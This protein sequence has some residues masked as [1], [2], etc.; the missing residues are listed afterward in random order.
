MG[1][2]WK[3]FW[4]GV[5]VG[6]PLLLFGGGEV[7][8]PAPTLRDPVFKAYYQSYNYEKMGD[9]RDAIRVLLPLYSKYPKSYTLN[10]RLGWLTYLNRQYG[11]SIKFYLKAIQALPNSIEP[12]L[13]LM[14][15]YLAMGNYD[16]SLAQGLVILK[17]DLYNYYG[18]LYYILG[19]EKKGLYSNEIILCEKML[20]LY[21][22]SVPFLVRLGVAKYLN[23]DKKEAKQIFKNVLILDPNN[24]TAK[25]YL[26]E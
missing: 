14:K 18:N 15:V 20:A 23:G 21:P 16:D 22:T 5:G 7:P 25:E 11:N 4:I 12:R 17:K 8:T 19:L 13:G 6:V 1:L 24:V 3:R 2:N 26:Q 9:Y 10:L